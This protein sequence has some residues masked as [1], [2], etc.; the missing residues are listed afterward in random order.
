RAH[1]GPRRHRRP[2]G[3]RRV[4]CRDLRA[5]R[6]ASGAEHREGVRDLP[7]EPGEGGEE[8]DPHPGPLPQG[9]GS[10]QTY[11]TSTISNSFTPPGVRTSATSPANFPMRARAMGEE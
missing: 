6:G 9:R 5:P 11:L 10:A 1:E 8:E 3:A 7:G 4:V 2:Q